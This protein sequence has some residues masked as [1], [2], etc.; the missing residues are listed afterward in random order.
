MFSEV[1]NMIEN[2]PRAPAIWVFGEVRVTIG[3]ACEL[4]CVA[5]LALLVVKA[6]ELEILAVVFAMTL[7]AGQFVVFP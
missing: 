3:K 2:D 7:G 1:G 4:L 6:I 5:A